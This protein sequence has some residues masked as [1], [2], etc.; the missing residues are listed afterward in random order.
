MKKNANAAKAEV[1]G[2]AITSSDNKVAV[3]YSSDSVKDVADDN[4]LTFTSNTK[5]A[6]NYASME[7]LTADP[8]DI[9]ASGYEKIVIDTD[10]DGDVDYVLYNNYQLGKVTKYSTSSDGS[11]TVSLKSGSYTVDDKADVVGFSP[12]A[13]IEYAAGTLAGQVRV[14]NVTLADNATETLTVSHS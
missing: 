11:I 4:N 9:G 6:Y 3:D 13:G 8:D 1:L 5:I 14:F 12:N 7:T 10:S 2:S